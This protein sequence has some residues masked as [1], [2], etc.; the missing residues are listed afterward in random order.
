MRLRR[1]A[2]GSSLSTGQSTTVKYVRRSCSSAECL[3][4]NMHSYLLL[5]CWVFSPDVAAS[6]GRRQRTVLATSDESTSPNVHR[7]VCCLIFFHMRLEISPI[8]KRAERRAPVWR[9]DFTTK[10]A[11]LQGR[12]LLELIQTHMTQKPMLRI[13]VGAVSCSRCACVAHK[14]HAREN[15]GAWAF[16]D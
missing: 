11:S 3:L 10:V 13:E 15:W 5:I 1:V 14:G 12:G 9:S 16:F 8:Q 4:D 2:A 6:R 7:R